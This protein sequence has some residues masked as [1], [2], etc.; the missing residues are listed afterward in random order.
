MYLDGLMPHQSDGVCWLLNNPRG[1][2]AWEMGVGKTAT[3]LRAHENAALDD[4]GPHLILCLASARENWR[5]EALRFA[6]D[7]DNLPRVQVLGPN[8]AIDPLA[9]VV[10]TNYDKL[11][12]PKVT[13]RLRARGPW[14]TLT[15]DEA[16][17]LK[18]P[19]AQKTKL[20]YGGATGTGSYKQTPLIQL[21]RRV[22]P[23]TGTPMPN[24]PGELWSHSFFLW[25]DAIKYS[26]KPMEYWQWELAF[27]E[28]RQTQYG[29]TVCGGKNLAELKERLAPHLHRLKRADVLDL[30]PLRI[31]T[32]PL[33]METTGGGRQTEAQIAG[34]DAVAELINKLSHYGNSIEKFDNST[35]DVYLACILGS[36]QQLATIRRETG[37]L[38]AIAGAL[39][40]KDELEH[41][42]P[43]TVVFCHHRDAIETVARGLAAFNPAVLH[44]GTPDAKRDEEIDRFQ[45][46]PAC[47]VFIG[48]I[49]AAGVSINLQAAERVVFVEASW[50]PA[51][52]DQALSRVYRAGQTKPVLVRFTYL[53]GSIDEA[54]NRALARK[55]AM[56]AQVVT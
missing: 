52:N 41:G 8:D 19:D 42:S 36:Y 14:G 17:V 21:A 23:L 3:A 16:H 10:V 13:R 53:K 56:I 30:P 4:P 22:W 9:D 28:L 40:L 25:P 35:L 29:T 34:A 50:S 6:M 44:G 15:L 1:M 5:R 32:W 51:D 49:K 26:G 11:L 2:L 7:P 45:N 12:N 31:D 43:K 20:I 33:D 48:Q 38:K 47:R 39:L 18:T 55:S 54:V 46:D 27:C 24:H 37:T